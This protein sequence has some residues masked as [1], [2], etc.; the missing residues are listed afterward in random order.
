MRVEKTING[1]KYII[2]PENKFEFDGIVVT[3]LKLN[4][5]HIRDVEFYNS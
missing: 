3:K 2:L 1:E 4:K 5:H